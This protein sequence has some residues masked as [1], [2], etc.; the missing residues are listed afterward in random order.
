MLCSLVLLWVLPR[1]PLFFFISQIAVLCFFVKASRWLSGVHLTGKKRKKR[2]RHSSQPP[3]SSL[4]I[5]GNLEK[6]H[7]ENSCKTVVNISSVPP[8][9]TNFYTEKVSNF[10]FVQ[11]YKS[12]R[13]NRFFII[14]TALRRKVVG[15]PPPHSKQYPFQQANDN[16]Q[17]RFEK[18]RVNNFKTV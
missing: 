16:K 14:L 4:K 9:G 15:F 12:M 6:G 10:I 5:Q 2:K 8:Q 13:Q 11:N 1:I 3:Q 17:I 18:T 7:L